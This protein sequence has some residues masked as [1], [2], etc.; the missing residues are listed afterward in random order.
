MS[1]N[2]YN[3]YLKYKNKY[4]QLKKQ[5]GGDY[6]MDNSGH[7]CGSYL[8]KNEG[9]QLFIDDILVDSKFNDCRD[10][11]FSTILK[12]A[13]DI[14]R[15]RGIMQLGL[16]DDS[17]MLLSENGNPRTKVNH[18]SAPFRWSLAYLKK[19]PSKPS[20]YS[21]YGYVHDD[22][23]VWISE[24]LAKLREIVDEYKKT[25]RIQYDL[26]DNGK[27]LQLTS[28]LLVTDPSLSNCGDVAKCFKTRA[29]YDASFTKFKE[30][31]DKFNVFVANKFLKYIMDQSAR[32]TS[33]GWENEFTLEYIVD[34]DKY[35][36]VYKI[37]DLNMYIKN[38][39]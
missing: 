17:F 16:E 37:V 13:E 10:R 15:E 5:M 4:I 3:K 2:F 39:V 19:D 1:N 24:S 30:Q 11:N 27:K 7:K 25:E 22:S 6:I 34:K 26:V 18:I 12:S 38:L 29:E 20:I 8:I 32:W 9:S 14:A 31:Y 35:T 33:L 28:K 36:A 23:K 21:S